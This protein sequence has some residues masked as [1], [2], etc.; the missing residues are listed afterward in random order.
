M[1]TK[2]NR[3]HLIVISGPSGAGKTSLGRALV[4]QINGIC[5]SVSHTTRK[6][7]KGENHSIEYFFISAHEFQ[8]MT[9]RNEFLEYAQVHGHYYGTGQNWVNHCLDSGQ[10][11]LLDIDVQGAQQ[12]MEKEPDAVTILILPPSRDVLKQRLM[13]RSLDHESVILDRMARASE[14][15]RAYNRYLYVII[16]DI[17]EEALLEL[18]SI[19]QSTRSGLLERCNPADSNEEARRIEEIVQTFKETQ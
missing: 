10:D 3:G 14:E 19:I 17:R 18:K 2:K 16:N 7:R 5:F 9:A 11:V 1:Q 6:P 12:I 8:V 15:V 4:E 13:D